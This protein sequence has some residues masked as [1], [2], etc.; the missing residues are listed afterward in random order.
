METKKNILGESSIMI[1]GYERTAAVEPCYAEEGTAL[2]ERLQDIIDNGRVLDELKTDAE[3]LAKFVS[4]KQSEPYVQPL[5]SAGQPQSAASA[6]D[7]AYMAML[8]ELSE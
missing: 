6:S 3:A 7:A 5:F 8:S 1:S 4:A 2:F